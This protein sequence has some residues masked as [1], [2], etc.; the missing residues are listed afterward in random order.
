MEWYKIKNY[1]EGLHNSEMIKEGGRISF[2]TGDKHAMLQI[3]ELRKEDSGLYYCKMK[4]IWG[5]G[6][7]L[8]VASKNSWTNKCRLT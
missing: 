5:P 7:E 3:R 4:D 2:E 8:H 1:N 6:S